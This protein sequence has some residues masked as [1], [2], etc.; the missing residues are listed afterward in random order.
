[1]SILTSQRYT[2]AV[3][4]VIAICL[5]A[6]VARDFVPEAKAQAKAE[7]Q[8]VIISGVDMNR[9]GAVPVSNGVLKDELAAIWIQAQKPIPV[10]ITHP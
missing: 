8:H 1:M 7:P 9:L 4:T 2:N 5:V 10:Y 3:L 6:I